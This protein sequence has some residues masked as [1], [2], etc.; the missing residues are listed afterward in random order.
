MDALEEVRQ[1]A[2]EMIARLREEHQRAIEPYIKILSDIES[3]RMPKVWLHF[4]DDHGPPT[5]DCDCPTCRIY[6][7]LDNDMSNS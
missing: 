6:F 4:P 1:R 5:R 3:I 2:L 7:G